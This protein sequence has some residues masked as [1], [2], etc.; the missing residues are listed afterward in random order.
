MVLNSASNSI[1]LT[2]DLLEPKRTHFPDWHPNFG[3]TNLCHFWIS[4]ENYLYNI[5]SRVF[6]NCS[7]LFLLETHQIQNLVTSF[8]ES[9]RSA[10]CFFLK[11]LQLNTVKFIPPLRGGKTPQFTY[12]PIYH[13]SVRNIWLGKQ[14]DECI[15]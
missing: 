10:F 11:S 4:T 9:P 2:L 12:E 3:Q 15:F 5:S 6:C 8:G 14:A 13:Y 7:F 1:T